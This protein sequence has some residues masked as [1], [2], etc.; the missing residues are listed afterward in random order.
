MVA[1]SPDKELKGLTRNP[2]RDDVG[3]FNVHHMR[4]LRIVAPAGWRFERASKRQGGGMEDYPI[5]RSVWR[6]LFAFVADWAMIVAAFWAMTLSVWCVAPAAFL[7]GSRQQAFGVLGHDASHRA[8]CK[9]R[10]WNDFWGTVSFVPLS[11]SFKKYR[12]FHLTH[13][14][15]LGTELDPEVQ[16]RKVMP[17][18]TYPSW[19]VLLDLFGIAAYDVGYFAKY[20]GPPEWYIFMAHLTAI[21]V[22]TMLGIWWVYPTW[23]V[24][25]A[26]TH[27]FFFRIR[28]W[29][30]HR[31]ES[32]LTVKWPWPIRWLITPHNI[33]VHW[34]HHRDPTIPFYRL[35]LDPKADTVMREWLAGR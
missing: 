10:F 3:A 13:H 22:L 1:I 35:R 29:G 21:V 9:S 24:I 20:L 12:D 15:H 28:A 23:I 4:A 17:G 6:W 31:G 33:W 32:T 5:S 16:L 18:Y 26:T 25:F 34:E 30:E 11:L 8:V 7:I 27:W 2:E 19:R 14:T